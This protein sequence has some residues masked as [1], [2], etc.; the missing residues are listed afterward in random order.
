MKTEKLIDKIT[1]ATFYEC[2]SRE[3]GCQSRT[4]VNMIQHL[5]YH[6]RPA[7]KIAKWVDGERHEK[8][9]RLPLLH[10]AER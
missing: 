9:V 4:M 8:K 10:R 3:S 1:A 7:S 6:H 2:P 5:K